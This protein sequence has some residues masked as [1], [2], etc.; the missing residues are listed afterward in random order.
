MPYFA[1]AKYLHF[2]GKKVIRTEQKLCTT[3]S[4]ESGSVLGNN[5]MSTKFGLGKKFV[6]QRQKSEAKSETKTKICAQAISCPVGRN[7]RHALPNHIC[8]G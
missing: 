1:S 2:Q 5:V 6:L 4:M 7:W 8:I 3:Q